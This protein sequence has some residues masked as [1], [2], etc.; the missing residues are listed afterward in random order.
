MAADDLKSQTTR[1]WI[2]SYE[3]NHRALVLFSRAVVTTLAVIAATLG[4]FAGIQ[5]RSEAYNPHAYAIG[6]SA[7]FAAACSY[8]AF[9]LYRR[10]VFNARILELESRVEEL[11]DKNWSLHEAELTALAARRDAAE[12]ANDA[13]SRFLATVSHEIRTPLNGILGMTGLLLDTTLTPEQATYVNAAKSSG[14]TLLGLIEDVLDFSKIEA[15]RLEFERGEF[16]LSQLVEDTIELLAPRAQAKG[17]ALACFVDDALP[18]RVVGDSARLRQVLLNLAG[19]AVKFTAEGGVAV[20]VEPDGHGIARF[21]VRDTGI[22]IAAE[23][24]RR[25]FQDFEQADGSATRR[26]GGTGLGLAISKRIVERAGGA[27]GVEST[28]GAGATFSF[29]WPLPAAGN[30]DSPLPWPDLTDRAVLLVSP[31]Q[32]ETSL[33]ARRLARWGATI[34]IATDEQSAVHKL[35]ERH[36]DAMLVDLAIA[37]RMSAVGHLASVN[38]TRRI[39]LL[40]PAERA[41]HGA[42]IPEDFNGYLMKPVR[43]ASLAARIEA[44]PEAPLVP[45]DTPAPFVAAAPDK[46]LAVLVAEDNEINALLARALLTRLGHRVTNAGD[47][48]TALIHWQAARDIDQPFDLVLMDLNMPKL[49]GLDAARRIR[50]L[51]G[52]QTRTPLYAL[53]A[54]ASAVDREACLDAGMDGF[55]AKPLERD[56]LKAILD[57]I[58]GTSGAPPA[59]SER[60][61]VA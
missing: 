10:R 36:W 55:L 48:E 27:I 37:R 21:S 3:R 40:T 49:G 1:S 14:E 32:I 58:S 19:N 30:Q 52:E 17:I 59:A 20:V 57:G 39:V 2:G 34:A 42:P 38:A 11:A 61:L 60:P 12:A 13:K 35:A 4:F 9:L 47:G 54:N 50:M 56:R 16:A 15:G 45:N 44:P 29:T 51:E 41:E 18:E 22:G 24:Q 31:S 25:I 33:L 28:L 26:F 7:L 6:A 53:T 23:D 46:S 8:I 5:L 43:A